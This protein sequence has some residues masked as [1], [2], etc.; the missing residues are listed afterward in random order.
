M[1]PGETD[2]EV[3]QRQIERKQKIM[4]QK[5]KEL[6]DK[7]ARIAAFMNMSRQMVDNT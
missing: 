1:N 4:A 3:R 6:E 5:Q 2:L 7:L